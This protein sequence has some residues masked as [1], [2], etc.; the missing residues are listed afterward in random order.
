MSDRAPG[1]RPDIARKLGHLIETLHPENRGPYTYQEI[2]DLIRQRAGDGDPTVSHGTIQS[3]RTGKVTNPSV[4]SL[5]ALA[6]FFG[7]PPSYFLDDTVSAAVDQR[8]REI[9]ESVERAGAG[10]ELAKALEDR[11]V[12]AVAFRLSGLSARSLR[13][14]KGI[15]EGF[16]QAEGLPAVDARKRGRRSG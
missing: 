5:R 10:D 9:K 2:A 4:D 6:S 12:R 15:V 8:I 14:I 16:R 11:E 7:V 13:G 1:D 3:I